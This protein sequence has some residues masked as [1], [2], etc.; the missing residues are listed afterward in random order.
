MCFLF[1]RIRSTGTGT[2]TGV[3]ENGNGARPLCEE[4]HP[5]LN[6]YAIC[7]VFPRRM[8]TPPIDVGT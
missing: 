4:G 5:W 8:K 6:I 1:I 2:T 7:L 3:L